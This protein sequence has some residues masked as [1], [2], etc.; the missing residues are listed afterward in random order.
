[1]AT[2]QVDLQQVFSQI[3]S[4]KEKLSLL[5]AAVCEMA[6]GTQAKNIS[7]YWTSVH[8]EPDA[9]ISAGQRAMEEGDPIPGTPDP[10]DVP[11]GAVPSE[12]PNPDPAVEKFQEKVN[13]DK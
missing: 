7:E 13:T 9:S 10:K 5:I 3:N 2:E 4:D 6:S 1:M 11:V 8:T 12:A